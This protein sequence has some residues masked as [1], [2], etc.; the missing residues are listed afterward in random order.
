MEF[1]LLAGD[2]PMITPGIKPEDISIDFGPLA[3]KKDLAPVF[4]G[5]WEGYEDEWWPS[6]WAVEKKV[7]FRIMQVAGYKAVFAGHDEKGDLEVMENLEAALKPG[8]TIPADVALPYPAFG[9]VGLN[10]STRPQLVQGDGWRGLRRISAFS[11]DDGCIFGPETFLG[12]V[13]EGITDDGRFF[14]LM[15]R[16]VSNRSVGVLLQK[17]CTE[18]T[19][20]YDS[21]SDPFLKNVMPKLFDKAISEADPASFKPRLDQLDAVVRSLKI[22]R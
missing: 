12:Y 15:R 20:S 1:S 2:D 19:N 21:R 8:A 13:F 3:Q 6:H 7:E 16:G 10:F 14:I 17:E 11:Q 5:Q 4:F 22:R 18:G 9:D